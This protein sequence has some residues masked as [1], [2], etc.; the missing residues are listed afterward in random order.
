MQSPYLK[1]L[2]VSTKKWCRREESNLHLCVRSTGPYTLD[3]DGKLLVGAV[4]FELTSS[5][6]QGMW[7]S[8]FPTPR[9]WCRLAGSNCVL[10]LFRPA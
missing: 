10:R 1:R 2:R 7:D 9:L 3:D 4:R 8:R 5:C 6:S